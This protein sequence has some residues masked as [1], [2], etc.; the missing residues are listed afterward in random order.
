METEVASFQAIGA[1]SFS[2][3][4]WMTTLIL[5]WDEVVVPIV[6]L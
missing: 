3:G 4:R 2:E 5:M 6:A 1:R